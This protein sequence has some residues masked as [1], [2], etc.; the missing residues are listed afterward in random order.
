MK[1][2]VIFGGVS[3]EHEISIVSAIALKKVLGERVGHF[4]FLDSAHRFYLIPTDSMKSKFFSS[5]EYKKCDELFLQRGSF[6]KKGVFGFKAVMPHTI[7]SLVHGAD[8]EDGA[9]SSLLEFYA[10]PFIAPRIESS[11]LSFNKALTKLYAASRG[12]KMLPYEI[13][14]RTSPN[15][16]TLAYP[17]ILKPARLGSSIG[18]SVVQSEGELDYARDLGFEYDDM[19][20]VES[21]KSGVKEYNL[22][23]CKVVEGGEESFRFSIIEEPSKKELLDFENKYLDFSRTAQVLQAD[24]SE[25]LAQS[26]KENFKKL[27]NNAF[28]GAL[29]RCDFFVI[30]N[31]V[32]LNEINPIPGSMANYLFED[33]AGTLELLAQNLPKKHA[34]KVSYKYI[35]QIHHAK[36]K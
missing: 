5:G 19:L 16:S 3:F 7:L 21:F 32:Y 11:V 34:I 29:I 24:I 30:D 9:L 25:E 31:E 4:I 23:G 10:L 27:Y 18:V 6:V 17:L 8:G 20:V 22:A 28:E 12:V 1:F 26:L 2:D 35:E 15:P 14:T 33:F 36:G 13:L